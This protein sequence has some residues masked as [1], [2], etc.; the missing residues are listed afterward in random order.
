MITYFVNKK[1]F[2]KFRKFDKRYYR[3][4]RDMFVNLVLNKFSK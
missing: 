2:S 3:I 1:S 4:Y